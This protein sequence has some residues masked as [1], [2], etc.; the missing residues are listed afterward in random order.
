MT[1]WKH[2][3]SIIISTTSVEGC[4]R[5]ED[6][7]FLDVYLDWHYDQIDSGLADPNL[8]FTDICKKISDT[9]YEIFVTDQTQADSYIAMVSAIGEQ[10]GYPVKATVVDHTE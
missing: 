10:I 4:T 5:H 8:D 7:L 2:T 9:A 6:P 1:I 3:K